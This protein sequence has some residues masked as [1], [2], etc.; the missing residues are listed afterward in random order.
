ME[1]D[2][3]ARGFGNERFLSRRL[4]SFGPIANSSTKSLIGV[5]VLLSRALQS[6]WNSESFVKIEST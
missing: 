1:N 5:D 4:P 3:V 6:A 2:P